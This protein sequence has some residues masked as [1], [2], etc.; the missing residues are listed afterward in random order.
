MKEVFPSVPLCSQRLKIF[1]YVSG[2][3]LSFWFSFFFFLNK[4]KDILTAPRDSM[5][6]GLKKNTK[7][8]ESWQL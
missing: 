6:W 4:M 3:F 5:I 8:L 7:C 2:F 1:F